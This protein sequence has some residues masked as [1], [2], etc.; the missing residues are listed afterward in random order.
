MKSEK[1]HGLSVGVQFWEQGSPFVE[2]SC[3][4]QHRSES[5]LHSRISSWK[6]CSERILWTSAEMS[7]GTFAC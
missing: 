6:W 4:G 5:V 2:C 7:L 3:E 1:E